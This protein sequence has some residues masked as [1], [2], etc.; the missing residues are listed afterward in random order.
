MQ[1]NEAHY[2]FEEIT[3]INNIIKIMSHNGVISRIE[4]KIITTAKMDGRS[5]TKQEM[6]DQDNKVYMWI[7]IVVLFSR[8][9]CTMCSF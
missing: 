2:A 6:A 9:N 3:R 8:G 1:K 7:V 4:R 5:S